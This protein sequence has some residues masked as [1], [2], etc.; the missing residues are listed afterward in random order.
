MASMTEVNKSTSMKDRLPIYGKRVSLEFT[1]PFL[2]ALIVEEL[3][4]QRLV[5]R[6]AAVIR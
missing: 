6:N 5:V 3:S 4:F 2:F 1:S